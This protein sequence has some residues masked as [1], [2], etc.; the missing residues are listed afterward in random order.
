MQM[1]PPLP[2]VSACVWRHIAA[3]SSA[4]ARNID[5]DAELPLIA[6]GVC[7]LFAK[8]LPGR[9]PAF[10]VLFERVDLRGK[11][12]LAHGGRTDL[13]GRR[14]FPRTS[15]SL[16][17]EPPDHDVADRYVW[18]L[19]SNNRSRFAPD[20]LGVFSEVYSQATA[21]NADAADARSPQEPRRDAAFHLAE[22]KGAHIQPPTRALVGIRTSP[23]P[24]LSRNARQPGR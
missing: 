9:S 10:S 12:S 2:L 14:A 21:R 23:G 19:G 7:R 13:T 15:H 5:F 6:S 8:A 22:V 11:T 4:A 24:R 16:S 17:G 3:P 18:R 20:H 1:P